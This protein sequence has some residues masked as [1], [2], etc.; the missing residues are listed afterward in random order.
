MEKEDN[1]IGTSREKDAERDK[2]LP[3]WLLTKVQAACIICVIY[4]TLF[5]LSD[6]FVDRR[7]WVHCGR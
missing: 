3:P 2:L 5:D 1:K 6:R 4:I 7:K